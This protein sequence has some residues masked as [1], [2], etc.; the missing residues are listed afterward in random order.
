MPLKTE[1]ANKY[2][3]SYE[4]KSYDSG[5]R[6]HWMFAGKWDLY[7]MPAATMLEGRC[8]R[9]PLNM[10]CC[11]VQERGPTMRFAAVPRFRRAMPSEPRMPFFHIFS[12]SHVGSEALSPAGRV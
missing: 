12:T 10:S 5:K 3:A 4:L 8:P 2:P 1:D 11:R 7:I 6:V 9:W